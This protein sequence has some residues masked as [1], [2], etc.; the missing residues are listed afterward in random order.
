MGVWPVRW[1]PRGDGSDHGQAGGGETAWHD[2]R[3]HLLDPA[4]VGSVAE[5]LVR[6]APCAVLVVRK[7][8]RLL[9]L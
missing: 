1:R 6:Q 5:R 8:L 9:P 4:L 7:N 2:Q 3:P